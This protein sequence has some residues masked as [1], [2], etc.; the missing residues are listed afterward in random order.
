M[1]ATVLTGTQGAVDD[2]LLEELEGT[3]NAEVKLDIALARSGV[4]P[5]L[6]LVRSYSRDTGR[7]VPPDELGH[8]VALRATLDGEPERDHATLMARIHAT[9]DNHAMLSELD[10]DVSVGK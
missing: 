2:L 6:D 5:A 8:R 10:K 1:V 9:S 7:L 3:A 4:W